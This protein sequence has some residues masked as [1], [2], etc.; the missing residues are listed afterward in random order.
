MRLDHPKEEGQGKSIWTLGDFGPA[1][2]EV[3]EASGGVQNYNLEMKLNFSVG[4]FKTLGILSEDGE[5]VYAW[6]LMNDLQISKWL[7][8]EDIEKLRNDREPVDTPS[9]PYKIQPENQGMLVWLSGPPGCGKSTT[10]QMMGREAG[11]V[12]YEAD[13]TMSYVNP[14]IPLDVDQPSMATVKQKPLKVTLLMPNL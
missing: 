14:F 6:G 13:C 10:G 1:R 8:D 9:C 2:Q 11:Y 3:Q 7:S 4:E 5:T 12:Y